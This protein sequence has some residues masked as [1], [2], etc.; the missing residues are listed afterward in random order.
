MT[1]QPLRFLQD[2]VF[3]LDESDEKGKLNYYY[4]NINIRI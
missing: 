1:T 3:S 2:F 4:T